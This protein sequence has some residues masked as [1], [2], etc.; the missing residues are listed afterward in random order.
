MSK[1]GFSP[2]NDPFVAAADDGSRCIVELSFEQ[3]R[4]SA[5]NRGLAL[6]RKAKSEADTQFEILRNAKVRA[7]IELNRC[8]ALCQKCEHDLTSAKLFAAEARL[9][10]E[11]KH[12]Y[13]PYQCAN[14][15]YASTDVSSVGVHGP[16]QVCSP[17]K[18]PPMFQMSP[19][20]ACNSPLSVG[21]SRCSQSAS[22]GS[23]GS[24]CSGKRNLMSKF[25]GVS[26]DGPDTKK[27]C[28]EAQQSLTFET[29]DWEEEIMNM[30][31]HFMTPIGKVPVKQEE[32][33]AEEYE[34]REL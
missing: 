34:E 4:L 21:I 6:A 13:P 18:N 28:S 15:P 12:G 2:S 27:H 31:D 20:Y 7:D 32:N 16:A 10:C 22:H 19:D 9:D 25:A 8:R 30:G 5:A 33:V 1:E 24:S 23:N 29:E 11:R 26:P 14:N 17:L 3:K